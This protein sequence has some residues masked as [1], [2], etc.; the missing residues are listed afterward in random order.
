MH[1]LWVY[2]SLKKDFCRNEVLFK[3]RYLGIAST[4]AF[5]QMHN[6]GSWPALIEIENARE[7]GVFAQGGNYILG[8]LYEVSEDCIQKIDEI[9]GVPD[10]FQRK[11]VFL[12]KISLCY[13]PLSLEVLNSIQ[14]DRKA[15]AYFYCK[16]LCSENKLI[17]FWSSDYETSDYES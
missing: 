3:E 12:E 11:E 7:L 5:Y 13:L 15:E 1:L 2:G 8:E 6:M 14:K 10:L 9:E 17:K 4:T 16:K